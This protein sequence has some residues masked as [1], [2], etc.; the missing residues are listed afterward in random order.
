MS[1]RKQ[2]TEP[3]T[4]TSL[5][6]FTEESDQ[7]AL[8]C[9]MRVIILGKNHPDDPSQWQEALEEFRLAYAKA[10]RAFQSTVSRTLSSLD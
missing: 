7:K 8:I 10:S 3:D 6:H 2:T 5:A 9:L 1:K 4:L